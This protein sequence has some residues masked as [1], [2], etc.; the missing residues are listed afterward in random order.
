[1]G[2][3]LELQKT[4]E[5]ISGIKKV[6][7]QPPASIILEYPAIVYS[8]SKIENVYA[9]NEVHKQDLGYDVTL[10]HPDPDNKA[11]LELS[12]LPNCSFDRFF[13]SDN[14]NHYKFILYY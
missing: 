7:Y 3:R 10:I 4:L 14:L 1:M 11:F 8:L 6:Y 12:K 9:D 13:V 5:R 2:S